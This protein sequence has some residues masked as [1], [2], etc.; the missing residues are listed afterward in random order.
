VGVGFGADN[1]AVFARYAPLDG[2][3]AVFRGRVFVAHSIYFQMLGEHGF[4]GLA[5]FL[6]LGLTTWRAARAIAKRTKDD[7]EFGPWMPALMRMVQVSLIGFAAG[8]AFLSIAYLD[9]PYYIMG[10]VV[11][12]GVL[13]RR[14]ANEQ[15]Q[16]ARGATA[17]ALRPGLAKK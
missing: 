2:D 7:P 6:L 13:E 5:L 3:F 4:V 17:L 1:Q 8:G 10:F 15:A 14:R 12:A 9:L 16:A 11:S